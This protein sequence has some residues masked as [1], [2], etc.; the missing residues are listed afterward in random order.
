MTPAQKRLARSLRADGMSLPAIAKLLGRSDTGIGVVVTGIVRGSNRRPD[1][2]Q[3]AAGRLQPREREAIAV[4]IGRG[5]SFRTIAGELGRWPSTVSREVN[6]NGGRE[7]YHAFAAHRRARACVRRPKPAK[8]V[9]GPLCDQVT[10]WLT[11]LWSPKEVAGRLR[12]EFKDDPMMQ[13]SH[14]TIY[15]SLYVQGRGELRRELARCLRRGR[16]VRKTQGQERRQG[17]IPDMVMIATD[18]QRS[19]T[20]RSR[21]TGRATSYRGRTPNP[22]SALSSSAQHGSCCSCTSPKSA[23]RTTSRRQCERRFGHC[24]GSSSAA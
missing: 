6:A 19:K 1:D 4:G 22:R 23:R 17:K 21:V 5:D 11:E 18:P 9:A 20:G 8:L 7:D 24:P 13:V 15:Q 2:W 3:P 12:R 16:T 10:E 14:E